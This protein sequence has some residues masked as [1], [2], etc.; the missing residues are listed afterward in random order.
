MRSL[1]QELSELQEDFAVQEPYWRIIVAPG[2]LSLT[3]A[4]MQDFDEYDYSAEQ[5]VPGLSYIRFKSEAD[6][7]K[8]LLLFSQRLAGVYG[9][10]QRVL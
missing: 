2:G 10:P 6:A 8:T 7:E 3:I 5:V 9:N 1:A 4:C